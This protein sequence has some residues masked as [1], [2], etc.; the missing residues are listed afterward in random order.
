M[1]IE[2]S[3]KDPH[4]AFSSNEIDELVFQEEVEEKLS[5]IWS[6]DDREFS[7]YNF[8]YRSVVPVD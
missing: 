7:T 2:L 6:P 4:L 5:E 3:W 1:Y 8:R